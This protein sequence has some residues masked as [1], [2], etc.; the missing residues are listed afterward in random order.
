MSVQKYNN[1]DDEKKL[2]ALSSRALECSPVK[3][4]K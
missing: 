4:E 1:I 3:N 2:Y